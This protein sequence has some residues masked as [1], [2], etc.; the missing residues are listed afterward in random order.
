MIPSN[1]NRF[2]SIVYD[3]SEG[4]LYVLARLLDVKGIEVDV[5][6]VCNVHTLVW[7]GAWNTM[8]SVLQHNVLC[9]NQFK[10]QCTPAHIIL[11]SSYS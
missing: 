7:G 3:A 10:T 2:A 5:A 6:N 9:H 8:H 4:R 1:S 11:C